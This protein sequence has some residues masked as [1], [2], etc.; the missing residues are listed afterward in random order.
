MNILETF[1]V[2]ILLYMAEFWIHVFFP[3]SLHFPPNIV[4]YVISQVIKT[5]L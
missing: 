5:S 1:L 4:S 2:C 3:L